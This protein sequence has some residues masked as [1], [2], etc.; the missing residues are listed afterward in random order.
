MKMKFWVKG[1]ST[2]PRPHEPPLNASLV[3]VLLKYENS[4]EPA[5]TAP[6]DAS[7][8]CQKTM[9]FLTLSRR[10]LTNWWRWHPV[11]WKQTKFKKV[12]TTEGVSVRHNIH[13]KNMPIQ[14]YWK[15][16]HQK[17]KI[18]RLKKSDFFLYFCSKHRLSILVRTAAMRRF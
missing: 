3:L 2:E 12:A 15:L 16:Y 14:I 11:D 18:F 9:L 7:Y 8:P 5:G 1:G 10:S 17:L 4:I 13:Y 6:L